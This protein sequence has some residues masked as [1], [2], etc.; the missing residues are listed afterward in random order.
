MRSRDVVT[1]CMGDVGKAVAL[2]ASMVPSDVQEKVRVGG[3]SMSM[4]D[5]AIEMGEARGREIEVNSLDA[6]EFGR[7]GLVQVDVQIR[8]SI[9]G[10]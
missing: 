4:R 7:K 10:F 2:L 8:V 3:D 1:T 5:I 6:E 9:C